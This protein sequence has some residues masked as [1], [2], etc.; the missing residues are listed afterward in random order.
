MK[1]IIID[2]TIESKNQLHAIL[3]EKLMLPDYYGRNLDALWDCL[4]GDIDLPL[5][6]EWKR[7]SQVRET[8]GDYGDKL[9][10]LLQSAEKEGIGFKLVID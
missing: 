1:K 4:T 7:F 8:L 5:T 3:K 10:E 6:L 9:L 2:E